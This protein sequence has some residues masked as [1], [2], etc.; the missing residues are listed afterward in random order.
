MTTTDFDL[1]TPAVLDRAANV[2]NA[3]GHTKEEYRSADG[4]CS[5]GAIAAASGLCPSDWLNNA[6]ADHHR[7]EQRTGALT[8]LRTLVGHLYPSSRP[9]Q[10][11]RRELVEQIAGWND[12][13]DRTS[14]QVITALRA[15]A[16]QAQP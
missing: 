8:A 4:Y 15:A 14:D 16:R 3:Y 6:T 13:P 1:T 9:E 2:I 12:H 7:P 11:S 5:A 10:M